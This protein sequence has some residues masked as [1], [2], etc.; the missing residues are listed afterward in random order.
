VNELRVE[1]GKDDVRHREN[2]TA[3]DELCNGAKQKAATINGGGFIS[4]L[5]SIKC[6]SKPFLI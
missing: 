6:R 4:K 3:C 5:R 2:L 1:R